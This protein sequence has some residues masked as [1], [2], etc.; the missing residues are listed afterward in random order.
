MNL[1]CLSGD[2]WSIVKEEGKYSRVGGTRQACIPRQVYSI[3]QGAT[4]LIVDDDPEI[5]HVVG[6]ILTD[7]GYRVEQA[8]NGRDVVDR[9]ATSRELP[10]IMLLDLMMPDVD[11][12][13]VLEHLRRNLLQEFPVL[14]ISAQRPDTSI[15][16]ALDSELRDFIAKPFELEEL[17]V[18]LQRLL[19]RSPRFAPAGQAQGGGCLRVYT[20]GSLR[21][22]VEDALLFDESWRNKPAKTIFKLLF[23]NRGKRYPKDMLTE[24]LWPETD[25]EVASNRLRVAVHE[26]RKMLGGRD[27]KQQAMKYIA[28]QEGAY[29]FDTTTS[30]WTD[31]EAFRQVL[32]EGRE[33]G[34]RGDLD[35]ALHAYQRGEALYQGDYLRDDLFLEW[36]VATREQLREAHLAMLGEAAHIHAVRGSPD[37]AAGFCRKIV[38]IEPWREEVYRRLME[39]LV[40]AGRPHEALRAFEECRRALHAEVEADPSP[41]TARLRDRILAG[42]RQAAVRG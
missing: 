31:A 1:F 9:L 4:V 18:R 7:E 8:A 11:G 40:A 35:E 34:E 39:Y 14:I 26:L 41:E 23:T 32:Q 30:Y 22:Y 42:S 36:T 37:Q 38:R 27:R 6:Q 13:D 16:K 17:L 33:A 28:Q 25:P 24:E 3:V 19:Q 12:Y 29:F 2:P 21:V 20:L 10:D 5:R 15:L